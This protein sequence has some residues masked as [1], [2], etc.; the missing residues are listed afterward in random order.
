VKEL[1]ARN[2]ELEG[3]IAKSSKDKQESQTSTDKLRARLE[4][5][6]RELL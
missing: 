5:K 1:E 3:T 4:E 6:E 2:I